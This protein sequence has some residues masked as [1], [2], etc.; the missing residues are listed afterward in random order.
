[1]KFIYP[2]FSKQQKSEENA[3]LLVN[4]EVP[5]T[6]EVRASKSAIPRSGQRLYSIDTFR[7]VCL[8]I[9]VFVNCESLDFFRLLLFVFFFFFLCLI[10][11]QKTDDGGRYWFFNHSLW[12]G[13]TVADL[14]FPWFVFLMGVSITLSLSSIMS[15]PFGW[16]SMLYKIFRRAAILFALGLVVNNCFVLEMC[17]VPGVL[18]RF[19]VSYL[20]CTLLVL[21]VPRISCRLNT[22]AFTGAFSIYVDR[23]L[24]WI[25]VGLMVA[26]WLLI[27]FLL[28]VPGCPTGYIGPGGL[29]LGP[30]LA[31]CTGGAARYIDLL[32]FG[33]AHIYQTPT[34]QQV[35]KRRERVAIVLL[36]LVDS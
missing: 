27:T 20:V 24:E 21:F 2:R 17:R 14:V 34:A 13:L 30:E 4:Q 15:R 12:D 28:P 36:L 35:C 9:M 26:A 3:P 6:A 31:S 16:G 29:S 22:H 32:V 19:A 11:H 8:A 7:G 1:M 33:E 23:I 5:E 18:Q 10:C 25:I